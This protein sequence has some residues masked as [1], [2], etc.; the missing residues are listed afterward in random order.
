MNEIVEKLFAR[1]AEFVLA[2]RR[3][4][5]AT[6]RLQF[7]SGFTFRDA[8]ALVPYFD[9]LGITDCYAS[10]YF[11]ARPGSTHGY[12]ITDHQSL[13]SEIGTEADYEDFVNALKSHGMGQILDIVPNHM[14]IIGNQNS[15][16]NDVLE[17]GPASPFAT[18]FDISWEASHRP[19]MQ[20]R[21][22]LPVLGDPYGKVLESGLIRLEYDNGAFRIRYFDH[23]FP[24][25]PQTYEVVLNTRLADL[26]NLIEADSPA[27]AEYHSILTS[28]RHLPSRTETSPEKMAERHREKE[29]IKRRLAGLIQQNPVLADFLDANIQH[30]NGI[31]GNSP[32]YDALD[33]L[34]TAQVYRLSYW[35][36]ASDEINYR[37]FFDVNELAALSMERPEVF[38]ATHSKVMQLLAQGS[39]TGL[40]ID[41]VDGLLNP[42]EY[43]E[44]LQ[45]HYIVACA[46]HLHET[47]DQDAGT[48]WDEI[49]PAFA[50]R[51][52]QEFTALASDMFGPKQT[53]VS[54]QILVSPI[55]PS[56]FAALEGRPPLYVVVEK[57][58]GAAERLVHDWPVYGTTGYDFLNAVNALFVNAANA[59]NFTALYQAWT[60]ED[61]PFAE[62]LYRNKLLI[63]QVAL[64]SEVQ[65]LAHQLD[66]LAQK[67]RW[68]RDFSLNSLRFALRE[69]IAGFPVYRSYVSENATRDDDQ[70]HLLRAIHRAKARHP[71]VS[72][73]L[74]HYVRDMLLA[75]PPESASE[76]DR[77]ERS[78][79]TGKFQQ[80]TSP[81][82]AKG[83]E[84][85]TFY[86]YNRLLSLNEVGGDPTRFGAQ[87]AAL[88]ETLQQ[89]QEKHPFA[90][91]PLATHDTKRGEDVRARLNVLSEL[92]GEW[93]DN[94]AH[95]NK[96]NAPLRRTVDELGVPDANEEYFFYQ[97]ILGS[98]PLDPCSAEE[99]ADYVRRIQEYMVKAIREAKV[100]TSWVNPVA[101]YDDAMHEFVSRVLDRE[102]NTEFLQHFRTFQ[103]RI[104]HY[105]LFNS[106]AQT[107]LR[108][109]APGVP[110]TYQGTELWDF[111]LVDPDNRRPVDYER[112]AQ[113]LR[114]I[115]S[116]L[117]DSNVDGRA[118]ARD[119]ISSKEDGRI[120]LHITQAGLRFR[121]RH[122]DLLTTGD[123]LPA[124][125]AGPCDD[126]IFACVRR[127]ADTSALI[128]V[129]RLLTRLIPGERI[130]VGPET[131]RDTL[132]QLPEESPGQ[133]RNIFTNELVTVSNG[134]V[135]ACDV[136]AN[137]PV[138]ILSGPVGG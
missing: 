20:G 45:Q 56:P 15:W 92:P 125:A 57:I 107:V 2:Q 3:L 28:L 117:A 82:M 48:N 21:L 121:R 102:S 91:S 38:A 32:S 26:E 78:R 46:R 113:M 120:K 80:L 126:H 127:H 111:S 73:A 4:P 88:H 25:D 112:R 49:A 12:D 123:Y 109:T 31:P 59:A 13:N 134:A 130:P 75:R 35:R 135:R 23:V 89:R 7:H 16:W 50:E 131:W 136:F 17:N 8:A 64:S 119:L 65:M 29:I 51:V 70:K 14:G 95:W 133:W 99:Y 74:F 24:V 22:L 43:L 61:S 5:A 69:I 129:P 37:R 132:I 71:A 27:L 105:G 101:A 124:T 81:V 83:L 67:D 72:R 87:P 36:V 1:T 94:L 76:G 55:L 42:R 11:S 60:G 44:R 128:A 39:V 103:R 63:L 98:W 90:L 33:H 104:S 110:D 18:Y 137:F 34:L 100:H 86:V 116:R 52:K 106:L 68:S 115:Q 96:I 97:T 30:F 9:A 93:R 58:L 138:A 66:R 62:L 10:P 53:G 118:F 77:G 19:G 85:T 114:D 54:T 122:S 84:D 6:Y 41:H 108:I 79:F 47:K 40:R